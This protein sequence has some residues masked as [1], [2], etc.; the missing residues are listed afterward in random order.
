MTTFNCPAISSPSTMITINMN[1]TNHINNSQP[2]PAKFFIRMKRNPV[3][4]SWT[5]LQLQLQDSK[6]KGVRGMGILSTLEKQRPAPTEKDS[7]LKETPHKNAA[8]F[9]F[10]PTQST[11]SLSSTFTTNDISKNITV[12]DQL[13]ENISSHRNSTSLR[14]MS[15][16]FY[17]E[18][19]K[20]DGSVQQDTEGSG[21]VNVFPSHKM[22]QISLD[23][24]HISN[25]SRTCHLYLK[26]IWHNN[27]NIIVGLDNKEMAGISDFISDLTKYNSL[28]LDEIS[29]SRVSNSKHNSNIMPT[30]VVSGL[31]SL[32]NADKAFAV[33]SADSVAKFLTIPLHRPYVS[34]NIKETKHPFVANANLPVELNPSEYSILSYNLASLMLRNKYIHSAT[35]HNKDSISSNAP[36]SYDLSSCN[37]VKTE[38]VSDNLEPAIP[39]SVPG[40]LPAQRLNMQLPSINHYVGKFLIPSHTIIG[41]TQD[42]G[43]YIEEFDYDVTQFSGNNYFLEE[44]KLYLLTRNPII[45]KSKSKEVVFLNSLTSSN[46]IEF[47]GN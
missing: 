13:T 22:S 1:D 14:N 32:E 15:R 4:S 46:Q 10:I 41:Q 5:H 24:V 38:F 6:I 18:S 20:E 47:L 34:L 26:S 31:P 39:I 3:T 19:I 8:A 7:A 27:E 29:E 30:T 9:F 35:T 45:R 28:Y 12:G 2:V 33:E 37:T 42:K 16:L 40:S 25:A 44:E 17:Q 11:V 23:H 36:S 43:Q 21:M